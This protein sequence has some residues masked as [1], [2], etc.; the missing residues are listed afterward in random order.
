MRLRQL[1]RCTT[2]VILISGCQT[3]NAAS[4]VPALIAAPDDASRAALRQT[5]SAIFGG[6]DVPLAD[7]ALTKSSLLLIERD[8]RGSLDA[9]PATGRVMEEPIR[10]R[11]VKSGDECVL[12]D[13]RDESRHLLSDTTCVPE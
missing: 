1:A 5:V 4:D 3:M 9:P 7:N 13:L 12:V 11:L 10:F 6:Q 2:A 8:P